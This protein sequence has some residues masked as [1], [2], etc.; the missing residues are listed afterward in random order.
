MIESR[1]IKMLEFDEETPVDAANSSKT[2]RH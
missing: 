1:M 2:S